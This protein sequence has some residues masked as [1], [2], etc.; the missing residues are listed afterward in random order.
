MKTQKKHP[1]KISN[2]YRKALEGLYDGVYFVDKNRKILFW[3]EAAARISGYLKEDVEGCCCHDNTLKCTDKNGKPLCKKLCPSSLCIKHKIPKTDRVYLKTKLGDRLLIDIHATPLLDKNNVALGS[4][5]VFRDASPYERL[6]KAYNRIRKLSITDPLTSL[7]NKRA[8]NQ[9]LDAEIRMVRRYKFHLSIAIADID[10]FK[11]V[12]DNYGHQ[13]GD[14]VLKQISMILESNLRSVDMIGRMGG[15]EFIVIF[16]HT[17][18]EDAFIPVERL[19]R[20]VEQFKFKKIN[21]NIT[22]SFGI[23]DF[24]D[25]DTRV[26]FVKRADE[27]LYKAKNSGR[28]RVVMDK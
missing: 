18:K 23:T 21:K 27:Y 6:E 19:C 26:S 3:S 11:K 12:N 13:S 5:V 17:K 9:R 22:I 25:K 16:P 8:I 28:N 7:L 15:D 10:F 20:I 1:I 24:S 2:F 14:S 4:V